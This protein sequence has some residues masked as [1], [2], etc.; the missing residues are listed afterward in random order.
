MTEKIRKCIDNGNLVALAALDLSKAFDSLS[1]E[2]ILKKLDDM[3]LNETATRWIK[4]YLS[5]RKQLVRFG[6]IESNIENIESGVPQGSILGPLLFIT[7][8]ND[9]YSKLE[10]YEIFTYADDMQIVIEGENVN[11]LGSKLEVAIQKANDYYNNNSLLCN[12]TKTEIMLLGSK[13]KLGSAGQL[14]GKVT[15]GEESKILTGEESLKLLG[16]HIDPSLDWNKH[17]K[18]VKQRAVNSIRNL[19]RVNN[20]I[21]MKQKR[22]LYTSLVTPH[23]SYA[24]IIWNGCSRLNQNKIQ[25]AQNFAAKSMLGVKKYTSST[26]ALKKLEMIPLSGKRKINLA[27]HVKKSL[28]GRAPANI[29]EMYKKQLSITNNRSAARRDLNIPKHRLQQYQNGAF[30]NSIKA[31]NSLSVKIR[32]DNLSTFKKHLQTSMTKEYVKI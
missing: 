23:F 11:E 19:H 24:D 2:L 29:Q 20:L 1:H 22:I 32:D 28:E 10:E 15:N 13:K 25:Q 17:S 31:W 12:P 3:G 26:S 5:N 16:I 8:T 9:L 21:P 4:S 30:Y 14:R 7:C 6:K 27:V 18:L